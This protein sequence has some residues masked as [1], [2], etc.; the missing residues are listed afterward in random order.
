LIAPFC[1]EFIWEG[2][3]G[4]ATQSVQPFKNKKQ[5]NIKIGRSQKKSGKKSP[6]V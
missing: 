3:K 6:V 1:S 4:F 5:K 2:L